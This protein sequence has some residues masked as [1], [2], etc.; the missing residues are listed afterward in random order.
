[1]RKLL[2]IYGRMFTPCANNFFV[3]YSRGVKR[4]WLWC[5]SDQIS[6]V[7]YRYL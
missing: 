3:F 5:S 6:K 7:N 2:R 4:G 1:M